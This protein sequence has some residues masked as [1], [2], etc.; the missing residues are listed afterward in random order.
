METAVQVSLLRV[1]E[2]FKF[3]RVGGRK[4]RDADVRIVAATNAT[5]SR[6]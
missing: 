5:C 3:T 2:T 6:W 1:L 4:E